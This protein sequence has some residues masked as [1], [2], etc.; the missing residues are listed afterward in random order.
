VDAILAS[1]HLLAPVRWLEENLGA[2]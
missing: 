2:L 1:L